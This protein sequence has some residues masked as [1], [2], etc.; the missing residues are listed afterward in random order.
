VPDRPLFRVEVAELAVRVREL[1]DIVDED[2][3]TAATGMAY[4]IQGAVT[5][6]D[7]VLGHFD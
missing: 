6:L 2:K 5:A 4:R 1:M 7:A 3:V